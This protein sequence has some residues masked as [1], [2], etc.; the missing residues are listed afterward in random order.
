M[1]LTSKLRI[2]FILFRVV[3]LLFGTLLLPVIVFIPFP[4]GMWA[5]TILLALLCFFYTFGILA[6]WYAIRH[7]FPVI[8]LTDEGIQKRNFLGLGL[9][10]YYYPWTELSGYTSGSFSLE[11]TSFSRLKIMKG[12]RCVI[13][14]DEATHDNFEA[15]R[16]ETEKR[17]PHL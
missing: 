13:H 8:K 6:G 9:I 2:W 4:D 17:L 10:R 12:E 15:L 11:F 16:K 1:I 14:F 7:G 5:M 3:A